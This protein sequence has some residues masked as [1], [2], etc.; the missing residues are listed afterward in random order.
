MYI[1]CTCF[2]TVTLQ[3]Y[4]SP[5]LVDIKPLWNLYCGNKLQQT[6]SW[7]YDKALGVNTARQ[8]KMQVA[9]LVDLLTDW[10]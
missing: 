10:T 9:L 1:I 6:P 5:V 3:F 2:V 4:K 7:Q 8:N